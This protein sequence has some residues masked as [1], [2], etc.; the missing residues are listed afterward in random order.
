MGETSLGTT[1][2]LHHDWQDQALPVAASTARRAS[3]EIRCARYSALPCR[4]LLRP[5]AGTDRPSSAFG[6]KRFFNASSNA[7]TRNTPSEPAPVT[8]TRTSDGRLATNT[9]TSA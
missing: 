3:T 8:A 9:P 5:A 4:S 7:V 1:V 6:E 2:S